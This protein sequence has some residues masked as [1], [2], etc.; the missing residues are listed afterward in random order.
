MRK[1]YGNNLMCCLFME[2]G[3]AALRLIV[4]SWLD[5]PTWVPKV[6][7][8][9]LEAAWCDLIVVPFMC[10]VMWNLCVKRNHQYTSRFQA[11]AV[12]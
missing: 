9:P 11:F 4:R 5:V 7:T 3:T 6:S 1:Y 10:H 12:L 2:L 8:L